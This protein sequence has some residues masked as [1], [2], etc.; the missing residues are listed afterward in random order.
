MAAFELGGDTAGEGG[1]LA[2]GGGIAAVASVGD[3][4]SLGGVAAEFF[5]E[6]GEVRTHRT[7]G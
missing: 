7:L 1:E 4:R 6:A 3:D 2:I 5:D